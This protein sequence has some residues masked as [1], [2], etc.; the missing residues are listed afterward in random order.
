M[1]RFALLF[2]IAAAAMAQTSAPAA[3]SYKDL[4][5]PP[6]RPIAVPKIEKA[7]LPNGMRIYLLEDHEL[8]IVHG[9]ALVRTGNLFDPADK[10]GLA[11]L[12]G[13]VLR[14][15]GTKSKTGEAI[16]L[17]LE[18]VAAHVEAQI[19]ETSGSVGFS[20]LKENAA[21]TL[22]VF[23]DVLTAPEFRQEKLE[24]AKSLARS[25]ISRRNDTPQSIRGRE[26]ASV[27]YGRDNPYG[28]Q[29][30]YSTI[31]AITRADLQGFYKRYFFPKNIMLAVWGDF[32]SAR[33]KADLEKLFAD[34]TVEQ[35]AVPPFPKVAAKD[36]A[37]AYL[38]V[39]IGISQT[40]FALG[41][42]SGELRD[43]D[44]PALETMA[45]ILGGGFHSRLVQT[46]RTRM[47]SVYDI[48]ATWGAAYDHPGIFEISGSTN[49]PSTV[50]TIDAVLKEV[51]RIRTTPVT[52]EELK[53]AKDTALNSLVFAFDTKTKSLNRALTYEYYGYPAEFIA[54]YQK[55]LAAVTAADILRVAKQYLDPAKLAIVAVGNPIGF[56]QPMEK[57]AHKVTTL[58]ITI[59][60]PS[61]ALATPDAA[62]LERG[63]RLLAAAQ[64]AV[65]GAEKLAAVK[66]FVESASLDAVN[67]NIHV[68]QTLR[69]L[70]PNYWREETTLPVAKAQIYTD[71][72]SGW[73]AMGPNAQALAGPQATQAN[74]DLFRSYICLLLSAQI[75]GR[76]VNAIGANTVEISDKN[77]NAARLTLDAETHLPRSLSYDAVSVAGAPPAIQED[78]SDFRDVSGIKVPFQTK[79]TQNGNP[80]AVVTVSD[81]KINTGL[82]LEDIQKRP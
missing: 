75:E 10:I 44:Y 35:P 12:T 70:A 9:A 30:N 22:G 66:D 73:M 27:I 59:P 29:D 31:A 23:H 65:G 69:W 67:P 17:E 63:K 60:S 76:T 62:S 36:S 7:T 41:H 79:I 3:P 74:G 33:M 68:K 42:L 21:E 46:I 18:N 5:F 49:T 55:T 56:T 78:Y 25:A 57:L 43:K 15:G 1:S 19:G 61:G 14:T 52:D 8:P 34:W 16:D 48:S 51:N 37:G 11:A 24:L 38:A 81:F 32:D 26:F 39:K 53:T 54:Q 77:G 72:K 58:D 45:D 6:L 64:Q 80:Y 2:S 13:Q 4:K 71:G 47:G 28:W 20:A 82:K 50:E 40:F